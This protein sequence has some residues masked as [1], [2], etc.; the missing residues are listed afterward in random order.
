[1]MARGSSE[2]GLSLVTMVMS[3][4]RVAT[5]ELNAMFGAGTEDGA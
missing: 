1:M 3:A 5:E 2:R 4:S